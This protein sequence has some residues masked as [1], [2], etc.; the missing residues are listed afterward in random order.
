MKLE[1][2]GTGCPRC[3]RLAENALLALKELGIEAEVV[4]VTD[5][6]KMVSYG[7]LMTPGLVVDGKIKSAGQVLSIQQIKELL[8]REER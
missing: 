6:K 7:P 8:S 5:L 4:K 1:I 3:E 2:L